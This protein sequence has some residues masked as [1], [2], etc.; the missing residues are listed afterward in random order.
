MGELCS[1]SLQN[2]RANATEKTF[3]LPVTLL[4]AIRR[5]F[6]ANIVSP[7]RMPSMEVLITFWS[8]AK[9]IL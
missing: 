6:D 8:L 2:C 5:T 3:M 1:T 7:R 4:V 9:N